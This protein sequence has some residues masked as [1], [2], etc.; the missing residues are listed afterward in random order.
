MEIALKQRRQ[1]IVGNCKQLKT[2]MDS[3]NENRNPGKP[4]QMV[5]IKRPLSRK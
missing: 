2:D 5:P 3:F 4:I 1:Q